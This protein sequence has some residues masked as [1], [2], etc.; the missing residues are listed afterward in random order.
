MLAVALWCGHGGRWSCVCA[1]LGPLSVMGLVWCVLAS[2][3]EL[4]KCSLGW[5]LS[6][7][8]KSLFRCWRWMMVLRC[9]FTHCIPGRTSSNWSMLATGL[10]VLHMGPMPLVC[11]PWLLLIL[12]PLWWS[13]TRLLEDVSMWS[14]TLAVPRWSLE[15]GPRAIMLRWRVRDFH[16]S[17][18]PS[19]VIGKEGRTLVLCPFLTT[20]ELHCLSV[21]MVWYF[22]ALSL[23]AEIR[24]S[25]NTL[26]GLLTGLELWWR[27]STLSSLL[28]VKCNRWCRTKHRLT[29]SFWSSPTFSLNKFRI[30]RP[31]C[32]PRLNTFPAKVRPSISASRLCLRISFLIYVACCGN[33]WEMMVNVGVGLNCMVHTVVWWWWGLV[34]PCGFLLLWCPSTSFWGLCQLP[35]SPG[36]ATVSGLGWLRCCSFSMFVGLER[37]LLLVR[38]SSVSLHSDGSP[39]LARLLVP[40]AALPHWPKRHHS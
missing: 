26:I 5:M 36:P 17:C 22:H 4:L 29:G 39:G 40:L 33:D 9:W 23:H 24:S 18:F 3:M 2:W 38:L 30:H 35:F 8:S 7:C 10:M 34:V 21:F 20:L 15:C 1:P 37:H 27:T 31:W 16:V 25:R 14:V 13:Y 6:W 12:V 19:W 11:K 32:R 28:L